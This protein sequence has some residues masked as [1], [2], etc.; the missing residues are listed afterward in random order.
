MNN[1]DGK[2]DRVGALGLLAMTLS[3]LLVL[4][5]IYAVAFAG[6]WPA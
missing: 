1:E 3:M 6:K 4:G 2:V 5:V